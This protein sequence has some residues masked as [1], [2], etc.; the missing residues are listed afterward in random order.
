MASSKE[1]ISRF[2]DNNWSAIVADIAEL[3]SIQSIGDSATAGP[4]APWGKG[5]R[6]AL[7]C[8]LRMASRLGLQA[9]DCGGIIGFADVPGERD[10]QVA[11]I[12][13]LDVVP[14]GPGWSSDPFALQRR[15]GYLVG[16]GV[17]DDKGPAVLTLW[18]AR[19]LSTH[20][21]AADRKAVRILLGANEETGMDDARWYVRN[22]AAPDFLF[23]P[24]S[25]WPVV[26]GEKGSHN[27]ELAWK[28]DPQGKIVEIA[29]GT[30]RN[31]VAAS[32]RAIVRVSADELP[33]EKGV[34]VR[35]AGAG[36]SEV[37]ARG[38]G[39]HAAEPE[40]TVSAIGVLVRYLL[41]NGVGSVR[42]RRW[43]EFENIVFSST[44]GSAFGINATDDLFTP[45][46]I[47][48]GTIETRDGHFVQT[49]DCRY[50]KST[51]PDAISAGIEK[52]CVEYGV[53]YAEVHRG[54]LLYVDPERREVQVLLDCYAEWFGDAA[55]PVT[56]GGGTYAKRFPYAVGFGPIGDPDESTPSW[57]GGIHGPN[58]AASEGS[59]RRALCTYISALERLSVLRD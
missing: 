13:H 9:H 33:A 58:E 44:D 26:C 6:D 48:S 42:E 54:S 25:A 4:D 8:A 20:D 18:A 59:L 45:L 50:P 41:Q 49:T 7:N 27:A 21:C 46:T 11:T 47:I 37:L 30:V 35:A 16:R 24:D 53:E 57:V 51:S 39:G 3:V 19:F 14:A 34:T 31:A 28:C 32:A 40:G 12:A 1:C 5:P 10:G 52:V 43:L 22:Y 2:V 23:T 29:G 15:E 55:K 36:L 56:L 17:L 38:T